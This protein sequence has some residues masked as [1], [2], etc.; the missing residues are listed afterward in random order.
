VSCGPALFAV[1]AY[2]HATRD[3]DAAIAQAIGSL[4]EGEDR[5]T[6]WPMLRLGRP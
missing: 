5:L 2:Q 4:A 3:H 1:F 6:I